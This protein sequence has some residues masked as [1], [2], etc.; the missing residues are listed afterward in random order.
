MDKHAVDMMRYE[1]HIQ[2]QA[3][4]VNDDA[5]DLLFLTVFQISFRIKGNVVAP[6]SQK[7]ILSNPFPSRLIDQDDRP[8]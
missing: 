6:S 7:D 5:F 4:L 3:R 1:H 2:Q 8:R